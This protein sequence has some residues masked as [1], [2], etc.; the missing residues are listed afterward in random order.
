MFDPSPMSNPVVVDA[1]Y[2]SD[3]IAILSAAK[4]LATT[5]EGQVN[6]TYPLYKNV[7]IFIIHQ[8][9]YKKELGIATVDHVEVVDLEDV[10][11]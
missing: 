6:V 9:S 1:G 2:N 4:Q 3:F 11:K 8:I 10:E 5:L 7:N